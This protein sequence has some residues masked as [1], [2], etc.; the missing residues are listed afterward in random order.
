MSN[1]RKLDASTIGSLAFDNINLPHH[2]IDMA[3]RRVSNNE[4]LVF[5]PST[6]GC[7]YTPLFILRDCKK[8]FF[9]SIVTG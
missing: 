4:F 7:T 2:L 8:A 6:G 9:M 1:I 5:V 3:L